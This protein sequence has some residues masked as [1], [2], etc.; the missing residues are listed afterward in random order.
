M[1]PMRTFLTEENISAHK[2]YAKTLRLRHSIMEKSIP[3]IKGKS[4][5]EIEK[6]KLKKSDKEQILPNLSEYLAHE[7]FFKSFTTLPSN[8]QFIKKHYLSEEAFLYEIMTAGMKIKDGFVF[9]Y[10]GDRGEPKIQSCQSGVIPKCM[11]RLA[12]DV[13]EHAYFLDYRFEKEQY[14]KNALSHLDLSV[15]TSDK[16]K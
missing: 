1:N 7:L 8:A 2:E 3:E 12:V 10:L 6:M 5:F 13:C 9:I 16:T 15:L 14:L 4:I 11:P